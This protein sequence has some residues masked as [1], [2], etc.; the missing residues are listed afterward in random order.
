MAG[1][2]QK[3][4]LRRCTYGGTPFGTEAFVLEMEQRSGQR[5]RPKP[6]QDLNRD[7]TTASP[8]PD[9]SGSVAVA[10]LPGSPTPDPWMIPGPELRTCPLFPRLSHFCP[11]AG[12]PGVLIHDGKLAGVAA[13]NRVLNFTA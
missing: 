7:A 4:Q 5:L 1:R 2:P 3:Q 10:D 6:L 12:T 13:D 11:F 9:E 8:R